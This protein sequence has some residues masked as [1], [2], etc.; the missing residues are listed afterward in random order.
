M[1]GWDE[2]EMEWGQDGNGMEWDKM[3]Q[4]GKGMGCHVNGHGIKWDGI[5]WDGIG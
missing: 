2:M 3:G 1:I 5:R 4:D